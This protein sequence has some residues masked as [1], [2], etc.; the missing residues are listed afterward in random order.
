MLRN[1]PSFQVRP[2]EEDAEEENDEDNDDK[3]ASDIKKE[4]ELDDDRD[5]QDKVAPT[6]ELSLDV[7]E[8]S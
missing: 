7:V 6:S 2:V 3:S 5:L 1:L 8:G 4:Q